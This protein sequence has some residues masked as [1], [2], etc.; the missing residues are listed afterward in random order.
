MSSRYQPGAFN[1]VEKR[2]MSAPTLEQDFMSEEESVEKL[3][4]LETY[5]RPSIEELH[6]RWQIVREIVPDDVPIETFGY[7]TSPLV[8]EQ[9]A[10]GDNTL[11]K[12]FK[13]R[14]AYYA[15]KRA[16][17]RGVESVTT[18]SAG[19]HSQAVALVGSMFGIKVDINMPRNTPELKVRAT[20]DLGDKNYVTVDTDFDTFDDA[21]I[22]AESK[23]TKEVEYISPYDNYDVI[24]GQGTLAYEILLKN[25]DID[26]LL[27][28][29][30]GAG[31][32]ASTLE[33]V[34]AMKRAGLIKPTLKVV[35]V[36]LEGN[37]SLLETQKNNWIPAPA[38]KLD[39]LAEGGAVE[40]PGDIPSA[41]VGINEEH[42]E[43]EVIS[44]RDMARALWHVEN[45][46]K[47]RRPEDRLPI[48]ET[49]S[50]VTRAGAL[51]RAE[52]RNLEGGKGKENWMTITTGSNA[53][54]E[55]LDELRGLYLE[56]YNEAIQA[57][58]SE[59]IRL[60]STQVLGREC[61]ALSGFIGDQRS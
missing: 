34:D 50:L 43:I 32:L 20:R 39:T 30:G 53:S 59:R 60:Q 37:D 21:R 46:N 18:A 41:I 23:A 61:A 42:L 33:S 54:E 16:A 31:L 9:N 52:R 26:E 47:K 49:T 57:R 5:E 35:V 22:D 3:P 45:E 51:V 17:E 24:S 58:D 12:A 11:T 27:L 56:M 48:D 7:R 2:K 1:F 38:T 8:W 44:K 29:V 10:R 28:T 40:K 15:M 6:E 36:V 14:G 13:L 55:K 4:F 25:P 19:S